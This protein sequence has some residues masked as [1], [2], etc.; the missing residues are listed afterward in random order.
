MLISYF[1]AQSVNVVQALDGNKQ[2]NISY[3]AVSTDNTGDA[4]HTV[5]ME[6]EYRGEHPY[7][8]EIPD[9]QKLMNFLFKGQGYERTVRPVRN[10][11]TAVVVRMGLTMTQIFDMVSTLQKLAYAIFFQRQNWKYSLESVGLF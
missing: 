4:G 8:N 2:S 9:E 5:T 1:T 6:T 7:R 11:S 3:H 10:A